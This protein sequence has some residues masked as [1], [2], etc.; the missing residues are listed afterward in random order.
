M[1]LVLSTNRVDKLVLYRYDA[2]GNRAADRREGE[3]NQES[4]IRRDGRAARFDQHIG[5]RSVLLQ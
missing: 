3:V 1:E 2:G 5:E 4:G